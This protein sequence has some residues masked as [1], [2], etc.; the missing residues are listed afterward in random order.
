V[1]GAVA[2]A[3]ALTGGIFGTVCLWRVTTQAG[4]RPDPRTAHPHVRLRIVLLTTQL[5]VAVALLHYALVYV[6]DVSRLLRSDKG[7]TVE[8][9]DMF[10]LAGRMPYRS[11]DE[12]DFENLE[13]AVR[14]IPGVNVVGLGSAPFSYLPD[15]SQPIVAGGIETRATTRCVHPGYFAALGLPLLS[16]RD[17]TRSGAEAIVTASLAARVFP[18]GQPLGR[19]VTAT[20]KD[21]NIVGVVTDVTFGSPRAGKTPMV[22]VPCMAATH[23]MPSSYAQSILIRSS[24]RHADLRADIE[25]VVSALNTHYLFDSTDVTSILTGALRSERMLAFVSGASGILIVLLTGVGLYGFCEY[26][27]TLRRRELAIRAALGATPRQIRTSVLT[28]T[29]VVLICGSLLGIATT[30]SVRQLA[31][32]FHLELAATVPWYVGLSIVI[33]ATVTIMAVALPTLRAGRQDLSKAL[34]SE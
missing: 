29:I 11:L 18:D 27:A 15:A 8:G 33:M 28:E 25:R 9:L 12:R 20:R 2:L 10:L 16:G 13:H 31:T 21:W 24:R 34:R 19:T 7:F 23:P 17:L 32:H 22:F 1:G 3:A 30:Y 5:T 14:Q 4:V 6:A 26:L